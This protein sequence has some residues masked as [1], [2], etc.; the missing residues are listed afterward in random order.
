MDAKDLI[1]WE[2]QR[3]SASSS[4]HAVIM[5]KYIKSVLRNGI[6]W[7]HRLPLHCL[8]QPL[9]NSPN[10]NYPQ[11]C[12][13]RFTQQS[14]DFLTRKWIALKLM[15]RNLR[16]V[17]FQQF[18]HFMNEIQT[19]MRLCVRCTD[20]HSDYNPKKKKKIEKNRKC[21]KAQRDSSIIQCSC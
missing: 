11:R 19:I 16:F 3:M 21:C 7:N 15:V 2:K 9:H 10:I 12:V 1:G 17:D 20:Y 6:Q 4:K 5:L 8:P 18:S 14:N 13:K